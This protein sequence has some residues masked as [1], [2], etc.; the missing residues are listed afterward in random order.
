MS[1]V[2]NKEKNKENEKF[3]KIPENATLL[4][5]KKWKIRII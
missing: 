5:W 4:D 1:T 2:N 3:T